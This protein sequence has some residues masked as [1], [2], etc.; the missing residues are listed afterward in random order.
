MDKLNKKELFELVTAQQSE[1]ERYKSRF[2]DLVAAHKGLLK[3]KDLLENSLK[4]V[5]K[6]STGKTVEQSEV[7]D[8][9]ESG[10]SFIEESEGEESP[11]HLK[12]QLSMLMNSLATLSEEKSRM[13]AAFQADKKLLRMEKIQSEN[14]IKEL[15]GRLEHETRAHLGEMENFK[16][17]LI[18]ERH[19]R[20]KEHN[21]HG[22][23]IR[24]LQKVVYEERA[25]K[26]TIEGTIENL[27]SEL[28]S[29]QKTIQQSKK[30]AAEAKAQLEALKD[31]LKNHQVNNGSVAEKLQQE[32]EMLK[33]QH[34]EN[35]I[36]EQEKLK[37]AE[38]KSRQ[39]AA[40]QEERVANLE[41]RL[42]E[43]SQTVGLYDRLRQSDQKA[44]DKLKE[45]ISQLEVEKSE[46]KSDE[47]IDEDLS[48][49]IQKFKQLI[50]D[51]KNTSGKQ[52]DVSS[53]V[54]EIVGDNAF[55]EEMHKAC[56][57][58]YDQLKYD[59]DLYKKQF[60]FNQKLNYPSFRVDTTNKDQELKM[61]VKKLKERISNL[62]QQLDEM[63]KMHRKEKEDL[64]QIL[65]KEKA[66]NQTKLQNIE[67]EWR[68]KV[69]SLE[70]QLA[71][72]RERA[73]G[74]ISEK[75]Q[76]LIDLKEAL[77]NLIPKRASNEKSSTEGEGIVLHYSEELARRDV[78]LSRLRKDKHILESE[79]RELR[80]EVAQ[81]DSH[82]N[83]L[84][85]LLHEQLERYCI[86]GLNS[87]NR[88]KVQ[89]L[90][91]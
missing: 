49:S 8:G 22:V 90:N 73:L 80:R 41:A 10:A 13:E 33:R 55:L 40:I 20:E 27:N 66:N 57:E 59:F 21:D 34:I 9:V 86:E 5:T 74:I 37:E 60:S 67:T 48:N 88:E 12:N 2:K 51:I 85:S 1:L 18:L 11:E 62:H 78:E 24:E 26:E 84:S 3:E 69:Q 87:A 50:C 42:A 77:N 54:K 83:H 61:Q 19:Q 82:K 65:L 44:I 30:E 81:I 79:L 63:E 53:I 32:L 28:A 72:Q 6:R 14:K 16:A 68:G 23:M 58:E 38:N 31:K 45:R 17:K 43:L 36:A 71:K 76:D 29:A 75:E 25:K 4:S 46:E 91:I 56:R 15:E 70:T 52:V 35:S 7:E 64:N 89:I 47:T 39:Q